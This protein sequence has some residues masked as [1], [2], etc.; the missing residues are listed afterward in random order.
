MDDAWFTE[1]A[2]ELGRCLTDARGCAE[3][4]EE[5][6]AFVA[7]FPDD[8]LRRSVVDAV[9]GAAAVSRVLFELV[10]QPRQL[11]LAAAKLCRETSEEA[12]GKLEGLHGR[13]D[14]HAAIA[15]LR[16]CAASCELLLDA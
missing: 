4:C 13:L 9:V 3:A 6:L 14:T 11:V 16:R 15:A 5:L 2:D 12:A 8:E 1:V 7:P 10:D